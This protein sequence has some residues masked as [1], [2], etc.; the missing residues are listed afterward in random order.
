MCRN[1]RVKNEN[2]LEG[3]DLNDMYHR[4]CIQNTSLQSNTSLKSCGF[5]VGCDNYKL[6]NA[7]RLYFKFLSDE[8]AFIWKLKSLQSRFWKQRKTCTIFLFSSSWC[9]DCRP[10]SFRNWSVS[11]AMSATWN[12]SPAR[13]GDGSCPKLPRWQTRRRDLNWVGCSH[14]CMSRQ[15]LLG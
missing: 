2:C 4:L 11:I 1:G 8:L 15:S 13:W 10:P 6:Y 14:I 9:V 5:Q 12:S 7:S 3:S